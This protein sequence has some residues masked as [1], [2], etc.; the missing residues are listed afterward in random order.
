MQTG[1]FFQSKIHKTTR[2][3]KEN[4]KPSKTELYFKLK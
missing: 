2:K 3:K 1:L 4:P